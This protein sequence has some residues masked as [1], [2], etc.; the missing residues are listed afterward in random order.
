[1]PRPAIVI[2]VAVIAAVIAAGA[3]ALSGSDEPDGPFGGPPTE[4]AGTSR[5]RAAVA[6][7][8]VSFAYP[9]DWAPVER[10]REGQAVT[11]AGR[12]PDSDS[13]TAPTIQSRLLPDSD[14]SFESTFESTKQITRL[15]G[16]A[17][18][19]IASERSVE[20]AGAEEAR[21]VDFRYELPADEGSEPTRLLVVFAQT[22]DNV[23][24]TFGVGAPEGTGFDP[25][26]IVESLR[27]EDS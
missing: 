12:G 7:Q 18:T 22:P 15:S 3:L 9:R 11:L 13:G 19:E 23:F 20:L 17:D 4:P 5:Y 2:A 1:M 24:V 25:R 27:L 6:D 21:L 16:G 14:A 26:P 10:A 8:S